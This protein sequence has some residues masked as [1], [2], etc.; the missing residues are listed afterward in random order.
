M[1]TDV[2]TAATLRMGNA[3]VAAADLTDWSVIPSAIE[4]EAGLQTRGQE[5]WTRED[6]KV[7]TGIWECE[8][9]TF[10]SRFAGRGEFITIV[11]GELDCTAE[12]GTV[13]E[14]RAGD[15]MTFPEGW[16]GTWHVK[17]RVRKVYAEFKG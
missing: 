3:D 13:T 14:L 10:T 16:T 6:S 8:P 15:S 7:S 2:T 17:S 9:G 1:A 11:A 5:F 4:G 12:D